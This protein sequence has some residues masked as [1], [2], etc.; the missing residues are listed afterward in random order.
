MGPRQKVQSAAG[1]SVDVS[2]FGM[3]AQ[4]SGGII[5][6]PETM[7]G[8]LPKGSA[9]RLPPVDNAPGRLERGFYIQRRRVEQVRIGRCFERGHGPRSVA[10]V[11]LDDLLQDICVNS[12]LSPFPKLQ[13]P[14]PGPLI[15][16]GDRKSTRLNSS[17]A[18]IS[19]AVFCLK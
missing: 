12:V 11:A 9:P 5:P 10:L 13:P 8:T 1:Q 16:R 15:G 2:A 19:Y 17:H 14:S 7:K 6:N 18:N 4:A 3:S